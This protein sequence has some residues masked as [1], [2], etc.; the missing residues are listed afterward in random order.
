MYL[1]LLFSGVSNANSHPAIVASFDLW[2]HITQLF[3]KFLKAVKLI[4]SRGQGAVS[5]VV[6]EEA[7]LSVFQFS[8]Y[9]LLLK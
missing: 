4:R 6:L 1:D 9:S 7:S 5:V 2:R 8:Y 3:Q